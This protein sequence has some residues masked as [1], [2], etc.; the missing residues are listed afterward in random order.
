[1]NIDLVGAGS[2]EIF[3]TLAAGSSSVAFVGLTDRDDEQ[4]GVTTMRAGPVD[5]LS[6]S[7]LDGKLLVGAIRHA[8][9]LRR[10]ET[11]LDEMQS[12]AHVG[13]WEVDLQTGTVTWSHELYRLLGFGL[14]Q[15]VGYT[16][17]IDRV[18][19]DDREATVAS[20]E[21]AI[22]AHSP[23]IV[24]HRV[25]LP[26]GSERWVAAQGRAE[27]SADGRPERLIG[28]AQ[29]IT[30]RKAAAAAVL[31]QEL[32]DPLTGLPNRRLLVDRLEQAL[33]RLS[34]V[35]SMV[36]V[37]YLDID[38]FKVINDNLGYAA[39]D[40]LLLA[41]AARVR[42]LIR[43]EDTLARMDG[44]E[45]VVLCEGLS[46]QAEGTVVADRI[47][48]AMTEPLAWKG[49]ELVI[50]V[51]AGIA[52]AISPSVEAGI[53]LG[54]ADAAMYRAKAAGRARSAL[55]AETMRPTGVGR[56]DTET[57]LRQS[58]INGDLRVHYQPVVSL[59]NAR[60]VGPAGG[61]QAG[62]AGPDARSQMAPPH[63][64]GQSLRRPVR[65]TRPRRPHRL[66]TPRCR[67]QRG[68]PPAGDDR[69]CVDGR[70]AEDN[71]RA[72]HTPRPRRATQH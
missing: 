49:G 33:A 64:V 67:S 9:T 35:P 2:L 39:G 54:D 38:R 41:T 72:E 45:F 10:L 50:S 61:V 36:G 24:E 17:I 52:L 11:S 59:V 19:R 1:V 4:L 13:S 51:S 60:R 27:Y 25:S 55:F 29:D 8:I 62:E 14:D 34:R 71:R 42:D 48:A 66:R 69:K 7:A 46:D 28:M 16:Q 37:I 5:V 23:F 43:P 6:T 70:R 57:S 31:H 47:C 44:D 53:L 40:Q 30:E 21:T 68:R 26:D 20:I 15:A 32:H 22:G 65:A 3:D 63:D 58:I 18:H 12:F 56:L